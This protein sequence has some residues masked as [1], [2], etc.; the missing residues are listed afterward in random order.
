[1]ENL[2]SRTRQRNDHERNLEEKAYKEIC[3]FEK[4]RHED[5]SEV[6]EDKILFQPDIFRLDQIVTYTSYHDLYIKEFSQR[7]LKSLDDLYLLDLKTAIS[8]ESFDTL[9]KNNHEIMQKVMIIEKDIDADGVPDRID[10]DVQRNDLQTISDKSDTTKKT[11]VK[12]NDQEEERE[13]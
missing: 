11:Q 3:M 10:I 9:I 1:V 12:R 4:T 6:D 5:I 7:F 2:E 13:R 8:K